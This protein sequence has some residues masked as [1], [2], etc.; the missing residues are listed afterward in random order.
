MDAVLKRL[1][2]TPGGT[3]FTAADARTAA[4]LIMHGHATHAQIGAFLVALRLT[5]R[6]RDPEVV[7]A[8][9]EAMRDS[10]LR[11][12]DP[13]SG[14]GPAP[15][16]VDIVGTGGDGH[17]TFNVSTAAGIV[18][19]GAGCFV[20][21]HGSR[22]SSSSCGSADVLEALGCRLT[23]VKPDEVHE[24]LQDGR[25]CFLFAQSFHPA[26]RYVAV[27][28]K[29]L[30][31]RTLFNVLGPLANP[32]RPSAMVLGVHS[33]Y[34]G[35]IMAESLRLTGV[36]R[37]WIVNGAMGLDEIAPIGP[38]HVWILTEDG[39]VTRSTVSPSDFGLPEYPLD[40][41]SGGVTAADNAATMHRLLDGGLHGDERSNAVRDYVLMNAA[42][43]L[44]V[45]GTVA[46]L[47]EG[48]TVARESIASGKAKAALSAFVRATNRDDHG[49]TAAV[50]HHHVNKQ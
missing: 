40:L 36:K 37:A 34:L 31:V 48:V 22:A 23:N 39:T 7:S 17:N 19:A 49:G 35:P 26:M 32:A 11:V 16:L 24:M 3:G 2:D 21:K 9:A 46:S 8:I 50:G 28:R 42:A 47:P 33:E 20:A 43:L 29:E 14:D 38:T 1:V 30:G 18:A 12:P 25:F 44:L 10:A 6:D 27:P 41:V 5:M 4:G 45:A 13:P 15:Y